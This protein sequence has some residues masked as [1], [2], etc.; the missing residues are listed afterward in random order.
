MDWFWAKAREEKYK[1]KKAEHEKMQ[2]EMKEAF[3]L[4]KE[5]RYLGRLCV[6][7]NNNAWPYDHGIWFYRIEFD[8]VDMF[9]RI[10][11]HEFPF[12]KAKAILKP[13]A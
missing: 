13:N 5:F 1:K 8:S 2:E 12:W 6:I 4:G 11:S 3:P 9:G 10:E 7:T